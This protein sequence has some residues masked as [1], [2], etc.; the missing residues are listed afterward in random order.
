MDYLNSS[1]QFDFLPKSSLI[2]P[3]VY[4]SSSRQIPYLCNLIK[5]KKMDIYVGSISFKW[6][7]EKLREIFEPYGEVSATTIIID[8]ITRQNKGF[9]FVTMPND[10]EARAAIAALDGAEI[11][12]RKIIVNK[13]TPIKAGNLDK[14]KKKKKPYNAD[15]KAFKPFKGV[16]KKR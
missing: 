1:Q 16:G 13:S 8:K 4:G 2:H 5:I 14:D 7:E 9:G 11:D 15:N 3:I 10:E 12:E 6:K